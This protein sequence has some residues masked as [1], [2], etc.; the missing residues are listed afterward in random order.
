MSKLIPTSKNPDMV[1][2]YQNDSGDIQLDYND[3]ILKIFTEAS[4]FLVA[5]GDGES[6]RVTFQKDTYG[7]WKT[8]VAFPSGSSLGWAWSFGKYIDGE[9]VT[10]LNTS[11]NILPKTIQ[12]TMVAPELGKPMLFFISQDEYAYILED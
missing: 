5:R 12:P 2:L 1:Y 8:T 10:D 3:N 4:G 7:D 9:K 11:G 6:M